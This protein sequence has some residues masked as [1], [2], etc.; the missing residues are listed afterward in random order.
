M[1]EIEILVIFDNSKKEILDILSK[2]EYIF[3]KKIY[4]TYYEDPL[5]DTLKP[6]EN[7]RINEIFRVRRIEQECLITYKKNYFEGNHWVYSDEYETKAESF[8]MIEKI[9]GMLGLQ[10]QIVVHNTR[11]YYKYGDYEIVFEDVE[12]LGLFL[13]VEK[14]AASDFQ[15]VKKVKD[16]IRQFISSLGLKNWKELDLGKNQLMLRKK[17]NRNDIDVYV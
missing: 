14:M 12:N 6:E 16:E 11:Q 1:K 10:E 13:E 17:L 5:R 3:E 15:E 2:F 7:L 4:D 9:V 8:E